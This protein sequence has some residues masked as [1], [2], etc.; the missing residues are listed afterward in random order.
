MPSL[1]L[2][3]TN[4]MI[5]PCLIYWQPAVCRLAAEAQGPAVPPAA[6]RR[7]RCRSAGRP[8]SAVGQSGDSGNCYSA[9]IL[10]PLVLKQTFYREKGAQQNDSARESMRPSADTPF[11]SLLKHLLKAEGGAAEWL[12]AGWPHHVPLPAERS[13]RVDHVV[14]PES[15][16]VRGD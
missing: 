14:F 10:S 7:S 12:E 2:R 5:G 16:T 8:V 1:W 15:T 6:H 4:E 11:L 9:G 3:G 13:E